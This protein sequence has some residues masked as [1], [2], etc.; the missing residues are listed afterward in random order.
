MMMDFEKK[1]KVHK[2][3]LDESES[4]TKHTFDMAQ[5]ARKNQIKAPFHS[6]CHSGSY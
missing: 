3:D 6:E 5:A 1:F 2:N 4:K